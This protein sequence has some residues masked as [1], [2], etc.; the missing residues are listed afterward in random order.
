M[1]QCVIGQAAARQP[2]T[3]DLRGED[4]LGHHP[5]L[6]AAGAQARG[7]DPFEKSVMWCTL[8]TFDPVPNMT[9]PRYNV[10][11]ALGH[12]PS[13]IFCSLSRS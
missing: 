3:A 2:C 1:G 9:L 12:T 8:V 7:G 4:G 5:S 6:A 11:L 13:G 10:W